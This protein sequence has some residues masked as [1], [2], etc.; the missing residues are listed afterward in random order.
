MSRR[1]DPDAD[2]VRDPRPYDYGQAKAALARGSRDQDQAAQ[3]IAETAEEFAQAEE[4]YRVKLAEKIVYLHDEEGVAWSVA[5][6]LA[7]G[8]KEVAGLRRQR[9]IK[10]GL[11]DAAEQRGWQASANRRGLERLIDWSM[12]VAPDGQWEEGALPQ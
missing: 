9:D 5:P 8:D 7:R 11:K 4:R 1:W 6:D 12:R 2:E 3:W 10:E